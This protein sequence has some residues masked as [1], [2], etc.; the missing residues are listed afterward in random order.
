VSRFYYSTRGKIVNNDE[1]HACHLKSG[2]DFLT[3]K[4]RPRRKLPGST[5]MNQ[6]LYFSRKDIASFGFAIFSVTLFV[7]SPEQ[8][9][10]R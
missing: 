6:R 3:I 1:A 5:L 7:A 8:E 10:V 4:T 9:E 2:D